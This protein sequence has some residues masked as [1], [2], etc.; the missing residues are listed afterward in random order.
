MYKMTMTRRF[1]LGLMTGAIAV[2]GV[3]AG[4]AK[5]AEWRGWNIHIPGYPVSE[6]MDYF[7][8]AIEERTD[9]RLK[10]K[11]YHSG[12][13][14]NQPDA[15]EQVRL[16]GIEFAV[17]NLGPMGQTVP[18]T[19]V[20]SLPFIFKDLDHMHRVMDG[21]IG[22][23]I[24]AAMAEKGLVA[25]GW[26]DSGSRSFY[27]TKKPIETPADLKGMKVR[28]M[29]NDLF[30]GMIE[31]LGG[32]ATPM[33]FSEVYQ[34]LKTGVIDGAENNWASFESTNHYEVA[35]FYSDSK[36]LIIPECLCINKAVWDGLSKEDQEIVKKAAVE[37]AELQRK[38]WAEYDEASRKKVEAA[39]VKYNDVA[40]KQAFQDLMAPVYAKAI[41]ATPE[42]AALVEKIK[43]TD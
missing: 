31:Q 30:V 15:I 2:I 19:N 33:A 26:Y 4:Q 36:H 12:V 7:T 16:G 35:G 13:L 9:G 17:F 27:N 6:G 24:G 21:P 29:N 8:K 40:D 18:V 42:L 32:N 14:G 20:V 41:E 34:S 25:L 39:G 3:A 38:K 5:A 11:S 43:A 28:V 1:A 22:E 37:S 23:E 10:A